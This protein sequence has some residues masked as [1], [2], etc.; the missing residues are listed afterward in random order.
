MAVTY[1]TI[2]IALGGL[3][4]VPISYLYITRNDAVLYRYRYRASVEQQ[5]FIIQN[6]FRERGPEDEAV[7]IL[8]ALKDGNC[9]RAMTM[10]SA[11]PTSIA[12]TCEREGRYPLQDWS[13]VDR[14][15]IGKHVVFVFLVYRENRDERSR[16]TEGLAW[17][18]VESVGDRKW[19]VLSYQTYY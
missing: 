17:I 5:S 18:D 12:T 2:A 6:P 11:E 16:Q 3:I 13:I 4:L 15:D 1:K 14:T 9:E 19:R 7:K 8:Q 10:A